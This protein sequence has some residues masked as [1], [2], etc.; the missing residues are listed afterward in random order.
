MSIDIT[1]HIW[2]G[3]TVQDFIEE[4]APQL[5]LIMQGLSWRKPLLSCAELEKWTADNQ[6]YYKKPI[7]EV[8]Q[9]F[10]ERYGIR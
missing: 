6:S 2:E 9:F 1:K 7:P 4:L 5:D 3:W 10:A 8:V